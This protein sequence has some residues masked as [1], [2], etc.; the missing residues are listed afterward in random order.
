LQIQ[1]PTR[2]LGITLLLFL[3]R[4]HLL[5]FI[6]DLNIKK[7]HPLQFYFS[8]HNFDITVML[9]FIFLYFYIFIFLYLI[10]IYSDDGYNYELYIFIIDIQY[11]KHGQFVE[12]RP[13][14]K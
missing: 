6:F 4:L 14:I 13:N 3:S 2:L 5:H 10:M 9:N 7:P 1:S 12:N 8:L 11:N